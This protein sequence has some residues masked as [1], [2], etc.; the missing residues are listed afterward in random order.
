MICYKCGRG[1]NINRKETYD[2]EMVQGNM[3]LWHIVCPRPD[4]PDPLMEGAKEFAI[5]WSETEE[6]DDDD[7]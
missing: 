2:Y 7:D 6:D 3:K 4:E 1:V 5:D